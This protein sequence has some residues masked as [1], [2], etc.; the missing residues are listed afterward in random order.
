[1][2]KLHVLSIA[3]DD[4]VRDKSRRGTLNVRVANKL[5]EE[6]LKH[7]PEAS[8]TR[9]HNDEARYDHLREHLDSLVGAVGPNDYLWFQYNGHGS[10]VCGNYPIDLMG[11]WDE[12]GEMPFK[13]NNVLMDRQ[14]L[15]KKIEKIGGLKFVVMDSC[16][17][18]IDNAP[19]KNTIYVAGSASDT[20]CHSELSG[21]VIH[22]TLT[23]YS[24]PNIVSNGAYQAWNGLE[25]TDWSGKARPGEICIVRSNVVSPQFGIKE[26]HNLPTCVSAQDFYEKMTGETGFILSRF[27]P[28]TPVNPQM[29]KIFEEKR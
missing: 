4:W 25:F 6:I 5:I 13:G 27:I 1:M 20:T 19:P 16:H 14:E 17:S 10:N 29:L 24:V 12:G 28:K 22:P 2:V 7:T 9:M 11:T 8:V 23:R 15:L 21:G 3:Y 18:D 26:K